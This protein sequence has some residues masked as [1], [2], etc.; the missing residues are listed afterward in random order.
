MAPGCLIGESISCC[1][2]RDQLDWP[3]GA[4]RAMIVSIIKVSHFHRTNP[5]QVNLM[6][7]KFMS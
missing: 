1:E 7:S 4:E 6:P 2:S 3:M 5:V